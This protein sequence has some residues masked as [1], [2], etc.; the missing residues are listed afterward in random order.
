MAPSR[1]QGMAVRPTIFVARIDLFTISAGEKP[2]ADD[3][4]GRA[5]G[6][7]ARGD[8]IKLRRVEEIHA[9]GDGV[10]HLRESVGLAGLLA[11]SHGA[12]ADCRDF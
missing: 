7:R 4:L 6:L 11:V 3:L 12:E 10:I 9:L 1:N 8:R 5:I 2:F